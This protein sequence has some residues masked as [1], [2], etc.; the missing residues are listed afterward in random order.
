[1][2]S[3]PIFGG[4]S[5][6]VVPSEFFGY[7]S[8]DH[9][10][11]AESGSRKSLVRFGVIGAATWVLWDTDSGEILSGVDSSELSLVNTSLARFVDCV[12]KVG[13]MFP[14]YAPDSEYEDWEAAAVRVQEV[15]KGIDPEAYRE[16]LFW[17]EFRWELTMGEFHE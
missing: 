6:L 11:R 15:V 14:F 16:G 17:C 4:D 13:E 1:M 12:D 8:L 2:V 7:R 9:A 10:E 5:E 3:L